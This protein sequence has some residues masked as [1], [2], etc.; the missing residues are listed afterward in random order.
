[1]ML[2]IQQ[3]KKKE[4]GARKVPKNSCKWTRVNVSCQS[5]TETALSLLR[6]VLVPSYQ[7]T[8]NGLRKVTKIHVDGHI[9]TL[10]PLPTNQ[11]YLLFLQLK[12]LFL[13]R[14]LQK[15][16]SVTPLSHQTTK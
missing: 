13:L 6:T 12:K 2:E 11:V 5:Q 3:K 7:T 8:S 1:M 16:S 9:L 15:C 10:S 14:N 4:K